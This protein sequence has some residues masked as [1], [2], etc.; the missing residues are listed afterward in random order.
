MGESV[1]GDMFTNGLLILALILGFLT[2]WNNI[3]II[4]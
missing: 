1:E 3:D 4:F 2:A